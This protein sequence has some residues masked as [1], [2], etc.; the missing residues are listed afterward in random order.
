MNAANHKDF[1]TY[2]GLGSNV[3]PETNLQRAIDQL[4]HSVKIDKLSTIWETPPVGTYGPNFLNAVVLIRTDLSKDILRENILRQ[5]ETQL[6]RV[7]TDDPNAPRPI[8][9]DILIHD[10]QV[11]DEEIWSQVHVAVPLAELI[12]FYR[13]PTSGEPLIVISQRLESIT[14]IQPRLDIKFKSIAD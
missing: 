10:N 7:R 8:D 3:D 5:I 1:Q 6:G 2:I 11:T 12:P 9:L 14:P 13:N 4:Q